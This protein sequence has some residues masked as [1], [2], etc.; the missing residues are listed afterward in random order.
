MVGQSKII[1]AL[2]A[3]LPLAAA[4]EASAQS[5]PNKPV[6]VMVGFAPAGPADMIARIVGDKLSEFWGQPVLIENATGAAANVAGDR[7]AKA[8]PDGYTLL[9]ASNAQIVVNP[10]LYEKMPFDPAKDLITISQ[11][12]FTPN[13]LVVPND[14]PAKTVQELVTYARANPG[15]LTYASAGTGTTQ[16]L[17]AELFKSM[18]KLDIQHVPYR[19]ATPAITDLLGGRVTMFFGNIAPLVPLVREGKLRALAVTSGKRFGA[20][21]ELPTMIEAGFPG[22]EAVAAFGLMAPTG[23]P[24]AIVDKIHQ[25]QVKALAPAD[26]RKKLADVGMEVIASSP[27]EFA[28]ALAAE[29]PQWEKLIKEAGIKAGN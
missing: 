2:I 3:A 13:L 14:V 29:R 11:S 10:F 27:A 17:A 21:P 1:A 16:H 12:V 9:M 22:F 15:K 23:V 28:K 6:R 24:Q 20:V 19:G 25:D 4:G 7:A 5:Y 8:A 18:A 26:L